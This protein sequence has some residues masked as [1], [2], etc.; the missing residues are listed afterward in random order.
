MG[1]CTHMVE[2]RRG[3]EEQ[4]RDGQYGDDTVGIL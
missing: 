1:S 4:R 2:A 3:D